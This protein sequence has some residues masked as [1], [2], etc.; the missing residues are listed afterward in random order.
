[1]CPLC[2][3]G[4]CVSEAAVDYAPILAVWC[5]GKRTSTVYTHRSWPRIVA[6]NFN[7]MSPYV[8]PLNIFLL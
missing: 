6:P 2:T 4:T 5:H 8:T 1:M 7:H 3:Y